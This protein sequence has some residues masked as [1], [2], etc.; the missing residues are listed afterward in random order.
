MSRENRDEEMRAHFQ[1]LVEEIPD[2]TARIDS[3]KTITRVIR[4]RYLY[5]NAAGRTVLRIDRKFLVYQVFGSTGDG[6]PYYRMGE[7][8]SMLTWAYEQDFKVQFKYVDDEPKGMV[9]PMW[10][11]DLLNA[12]DFPKCMDP[13]FEKNPPRLY[14]KFLVPGA[15]DDIYL[16]PI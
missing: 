7:L 12:L 13:K 2:P 4:P 16:T 10:M 15:D 5:T 11:F 3:G 1:E 9:V 14:G 6:P 8:L